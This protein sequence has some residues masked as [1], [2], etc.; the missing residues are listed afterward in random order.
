MLVGVPANVKQNL[1]RDPKGLLNYM[2]TLKYLAEEA[3]KNKLED[4]SPTREQLVFGRS[5]VLAQASIDHQ[6]SQFKV[7]DAEEQKYYADHKAEFEQAKIKLIFL[8]F[9]PPGGSKDKPTRSEAEAQSKAD[10]LVKQLRGG[11]DF[12]KLAKENSDDPN[13]AA[14]ECDYGSPIHRGDRITEGVKTAIFALQPGAVSDP[15][16]QGSG[17]YIFKLVEKSNET[18]DE[19]KP[20]VL[21]QLKQ[22]HFKEWLEGIQKRYDVKIDNQAFFS[23]PALTK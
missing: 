4:Q 21:A 13:S 5:Q 9:S 6:N 22:A 18:F 20:K 11:A 15:I 17:F 10:D 14:R 2:F 23:S 19:V 16:K 12:A 7:D 1:T 3:E 8:S